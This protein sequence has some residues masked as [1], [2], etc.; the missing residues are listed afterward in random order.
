MTTRSRWA[1]LT[2]L[3]LA[4]TAGLAAKLDFWQ[5]EAVMESLRH[6][7][8]NMRFS[9]M[10][11]QGLLPR[12]PV[13]PT[14]TDS[15]LR[16]V[17]KWGGGPSVKVTGRDSLVFLSRGSEV[18]AIDFADTANPRI[19]SHIQAQGLVSRSVLI[20]N[21]LYVGSTG[22]YPKYIEVFDVTDPANATRLGQVQT[23]LNDLAVL[24]TLVYTVSD[25]SFKVWSFANPASPRLVG[26]CRDSG[27]TIS[28]GNGYAYLADRWGL[29][30]ID[31]RNPAAPRRVAAW[32]S[33]VISV[34]ARNTI[35]CVTL[36]NPNVPDQLDFYILDVTSPAS[37]RQLGHLANCGGYDIY[38]LDTLALLSGYYTG[39]HGF[40][41]LSIADSTHPRHVGSAANLDNG[42]G[43][44]ASC[45]RSRAYVA[46][47]LRGMSV[48]DVS[49]LSQ[50][51][52]D[53]VLLAAGS[54]ED[55]ALDRGRA[56]VA[57]DGFGMTI[58]DITNPTMPSELGCI[59][60]TRDMVTQTV[61]ARDSFA[62]M[63]WAPNRPWLRSVDVTDPTH[64]TMAGGAAVYDFPADMVLRDSLLY[65]AQYRR[66]EIVNVARPRQ[67]VLIGSCVLNGTAYNIALNDTIAYVAMG[68][69]GLKC[70]DIGNPAL[71]TVVGAWSGRTSGVKVTDTLAFV[72]GPYTGCVCLNVANPVMPQTVDSL[73]LTDTLW[74]N[75]I[76]I[77]GS[78]AYVG[79]ERI[80]T[81]DISDPANLRV[82]GSWTPPYLVE[83][84]EYCSPYLYPACYEAGV[85][86]LE[87]TAVGISEHR[88]EQPA[89]RLEVTP[90]PTRSGVLIRLTQAAGTEGIWTV[91]DVAGRI[92]GSGPVARG[93]HSA[94]IRLP[95]G[96]SGV[97]I[98]ELEVDNR[99][100]IG[101]VI[102]L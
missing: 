100:T 28:V 22:G 35:C 51:L 24:D 15:G 38:L 49:T 97:Y 58:L 41:I 60:S 52:R 95:A 57:G 14:A 19:L 79:G 25:D 71:P 8:P 102:K 72:V 85:C 13:A 36:G 70:I 90:N 78:R 4:A 86:V 46:D 30:V 3:L 31:V 84:L 26:T 37:P 54:A 42:Q 47:R 80:L 62:Y 87:S 23:M 93:S 45:A 18:V 40:R 67:P 66:F 1:G 17:G 74:W 92:V 75:D 44:W 88:T 98:V 33:A 101:R 9:A 94:T 5:H 20:G 29:Y 83:R 81:I 99:K 11:R 91:R 64:P 10:R 27:Y 55:V 68:N 76:V 96:P 2:V 21:R 7:P 69:A 16:L 39:G 82:R 43:V 73:W 61:A 12:Q 6:L 65:I 50:P 59:D 34:A 53:R 89:A 32:G 63:S 56:Y 77:A 48:F